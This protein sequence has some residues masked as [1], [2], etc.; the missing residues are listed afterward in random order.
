MG[1]SG[2]KILSKTKK[3]KSVKHTFF[4]QVKENKTDVLSNEKRMVRMR[5][6][7]KH[8]RRFLLLALGLALSNLGA[9]GLALGRAVLLLVLLGADLLDVR[10]VG[11]VVRAGD[12]GELQR[13]AL[14]NAVGRRLAVKAAVRA[15]PLDEARVLLAHV[16]GEA[17][18]AGEG[19]HGLRRQEAEGH[20][21]A[22][23]A[24]V[25]VE[26]REL[27]LDDTHG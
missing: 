8:G 26:L 14:G 19:Q 25:H 3:K 20:V 9:D 22:A 7:T 13:A 17:L 4:F 27:A 24:G 18:R 6:K 5:Q 12:A 10:E 2:R 15:G 1:R 21:L 11:T 16:H 23:V